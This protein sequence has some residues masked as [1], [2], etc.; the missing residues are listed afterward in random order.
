MQWE[1][2]PDAEELD[3]FKGYGNRHTLRFLKGAQH[4]RTS[5]IEPLVPHR[6]ASSTSRGL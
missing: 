3:V 6:N 5:R 4:Q 2:F 1:A